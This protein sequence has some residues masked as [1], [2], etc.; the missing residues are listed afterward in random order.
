MSLV[1]DDIVEHA[2]IKQEVLLGFN[3]SSTNRQSKILSVFFVAAFLFFHVRS[4]LQPQHR[5]NPLP[6]LRKRKLPYSNRPNRPRL[7]SIRRHQTPRRI[8]QRHGVRVRRVRDV[9]DQ[10]GINILMRYSTLTPNP[11]K[12]PPKSKKKGGSLTRYSPT[13]HL[14]ALLRGAPALRVAGC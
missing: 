10:R 6:T 4:T 7:P 9:H 3:S 11:L 12:N 5:P 8:I 13:S 1:A 2:Q 14:L